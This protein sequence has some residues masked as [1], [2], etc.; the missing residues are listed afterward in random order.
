MLV[1]LCNILYSL[2]LIFTL[3]CYSNVCANN[4]RISEDVAYMQY[5]LEEV[6]CD[7]TEKDKIVK[8][9]S[10]AQKYLL[11]NN[12]SEKYKFIIQ[13]ADSSNNKDISAVIYS[14][15]ALDYISYANNPEG[16]VLLNKATQLYQNEQL[17]LSKGV[18]LYIKGIVAKKLEKN[19]QETLQ[20][21]NEL[22]RYA[23]DNN[24]IKMQAIGNY[25]KSVVFYDFKEYDSLSALINRITDEELK[26]LRNR[27]FINLYNALGLSFVDKGKYDE[28]LS[29]FEK[30]LQYAEQKN[31]TAWIGIING[32]IGHVYYQKNNI[33][34]AIKYLKN[35]VKYSEAGT[36]YSSAAQALYLLGEIYYSHLNMPDSTEIFFQ[37]A[38]DLVKQYH[39]ASSILSIYN[40]L[41]LFYFKNKMFEKAYYFQNQYMALSDSVMPIELAYK[42]KNIETK[43]QLSNKD[44]EI[45]ILNAKNVIQKQE[46]KRTRALLINLSVIVL[47]L[48]VIL[49]IV[50]RSNKR[51]QQT[52]EKISQQKNEIEQKATELEKS[53]ITKDKI[54]AVLS[55]DLRA[56]LASLKGILDLLDNE[57]L[58][59]DEFSKVKNKVSEQLYQLNFVLDNL[60]HWSRSQLSKNNNV[61]KETIDI[62]QIIDSN[63]K[64]YAAAANDKNIVIANHIQQAFAIASYVQ[65]DI[66]VRNLLSN[67]IKFTP[68]NGSINIFAE[69]ENAF[70]KV[71]IEDN[72]IGIAEE[73]LNE[74]FSAQYS[75][76]RQGTKG[77]KGT[78]I[79]LWLCKE[80]IEKY[81]GTIEAK[82]NLK[83]GV[84][85]YFTIP[86]A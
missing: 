45:E 72:G 50:Y 85:F 42:Y 53:N 21:W 5:F 84:T 20:I 37:K 22:I 18:Y 38:V 46:A 73:V 9:Y 23:I 25:N 62:K 82:Q 16:L 49:A 59:T 66:V 40:K 12:S 78:G 8:Q 80:I 10:E 54:F 32:N 51:E 1:R 81:G 55:H 33:N 15:V 24:D 83:Q 6:K 43:F 48:I 77:E 74:L 63:I 44:H 86:A 4:N 68:F 30:C 47:L 70:I 7:V 41:H 56:P 35:D 71:A 27:E 13:Y 69:K 2:S 67:A 19:E 28:A 75:K 31:D 17:Q 26:Q 11:Q 39:I 14:R 60:L 36:E 64:L 58:T 79:G 52:N 76:S 3:L 29:T 57:K 61:V 65:V 34:K